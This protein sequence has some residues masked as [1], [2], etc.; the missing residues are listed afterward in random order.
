MI[1]SELELL[2]MGDMIENGYDPLSKEDIIRYWS[3]RL[4]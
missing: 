1:Y 3:E 2:I 4:D